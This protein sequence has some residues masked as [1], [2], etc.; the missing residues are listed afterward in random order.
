MNK[1][2]SMLLECLPPEPKNIRVEGDIGLW[3]DGEMILCSSEPA[4][5]LIANLLRDI[6]RD[7]T[8]VVK[9]GYFDPFEDDRN[10]E[11]DGYTGFYYID[12]E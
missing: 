2:L 1:L 9:T 11:T 4:C 10:G 12:F 3:S 5:R 7:S 6:L 8:I